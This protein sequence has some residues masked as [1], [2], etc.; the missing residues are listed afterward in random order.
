MG[1][2]SIPGNEEAC[3]GDEVLDMT[4]NYIEKIAEVYREQM[5]R[6]MTVEELTALWTIALQVRGEPDIFDGFE[7]LEVTTVTIKTKKR[8]KRQ[9]IQVG[10]IFAIP[11]SPGRWGFG[12][13]INLQASWQLVE[14]YAHV[15]S[16]PHYTPAV[17]SAELLFPSILMDVENAFWEGTWQII[18]SDPGFKAEGLDR[19]EYVTGNYKI[20]RVNSYVQEE[21]ASLAHAMK[22]PP[23]Q[24][25][26]LETTEERIK[27]ALRSRG[28]LEAKPT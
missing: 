7:E 18:H 15:D 11:L 13:I 6:Q 20:R 10:D 5:R 23:Y 27:E 25:V 4:Y 21:P 3:V 26:A 9:R 1:W 14:I 17:I 22:L 16:H 28:L 8:P 24:F 12:R 19:L 2:W